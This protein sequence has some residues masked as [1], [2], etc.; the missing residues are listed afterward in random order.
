MNL[1][2]YLLTDAM[3]HDCDIAV[4]V[5][6]DSD[7]CEPIRFAQEEFGVPVGLLNPHRTPSHALLKLKPAFVKQI[8]KGPLS[9]SQFPAAMSDARGKFSKPALW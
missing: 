4:V 6:N 3:R 9:A 2:T 5:S 1:A 7:L 8:R